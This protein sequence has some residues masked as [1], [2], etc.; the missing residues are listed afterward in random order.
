MRRLWVWFLVLGL[1]SI[2]L[3]AQITNVN[4]GTSYRVDPR[5]FEFFRETEDEVIKSHGTA[6]NA[7][8]I[9]RLENIKNSTRAYPDVGVTQTLYAVNFTTNQFYSLSATTRGVGTHCYVM[10]EDTKWNDSTVTQTIVNNVIAAFDS[11]AN[12]ILTKAP[13]YTPGTAPN[14]DGIY[15]L[16]TYYFGN[17]PDVDSEHRICILLLDIQDGYSGSGGYVGGYFHSYNQGTGTYSNRREIIYIDVYPANPVAID[18]LGTVAHEFQHMIHYNVDSDESTWV[19]EACSEF[20]DFVTTG[21]IRQN[22]SYGPNSNDS[23][24]VWSQEL[25]DYDQVAL[26]ANYFTDQTGATFNINQ[27]AQNAANSTVGVNAAL[28]ALGSSLTFDTM[29]ENW[30]VANYINDRTIDTKYGYQWIDF[31]PMSEYAYHSQFP[32]ATQP[33][34]SVNYTGTR[35]IAF[36]FGK[37]LTVNFNGN[38][39]S[40]VVYA[41]KIGDSGNAVEKMTLDGSNDGVWNFSDFGTTYDKIVLAVGNLTTSGAVSFTYSATAEAGTKELI[42]YDDNASNGFV[43]AGSNLGFGMKFT[44][45]TYPAKIDKIRLYVAGSSQPVQIRIYGSSGSNP[46]SQI[47]T[48]L[49]LTTPSVDG[50]WEIPIT[51]KPQIDSGDFYVVMIQASGNATSIGWDDSTGNIDRS[52]FYNGTS[53]VPSSTGLS[54]PWNARKWLIRAIVDSDTGFQDFSITSHT[55]TDYYAYKSTDAISFSW[56]SAGDDANY[57]IYITKEGGVE[58]EAGSTTSTNLGKNGD[59]WFTGGYGKY[60]VKVTAKGS[61]KDDK[62]STNTIANIYYTSLT[63]PVSSF[64]VLD[65][66]WDNSEF[67]LYRSGDTDLRLRWTDDGNDNASTTYSYEIVWDTATVTKSGVTVTSGSGN[68]WIETADQTFNLGAFKNTYA[69]VKMT[70]AN[71]STPTDRV[72]FEKRFYFRNFIWELLPGIYNDDY[73]QVVALGQNLQGSEAV[74]SLLRLVVDTPAYDNVLTA[75]G[76]G[77]WVGGSSFNTTSFG[78]AAIFKLYYN[79]GTTG[80]STD[81][82]QI[83]GDKTKATYRLNNSPLAVNSRLSFASQTEQTIYTLN[84]RYPELAGV[85]PIQGDIFYVGKVTSSIN[86]ATANGYK[87]MKWESGAWRDCR[88]VT[89]SGY[90][91]LTAGTIPGLKYKTQLTG[92]HP[93]PFNPETTITFAVETAQTVTME[94]YTAKGKIVKSVVINAVEGNNSYHWNGKDDRG[95]DMASGV[96]YCVLKADGKQFVRKMVMLK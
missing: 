68:E 34:I 15:G 5:S 66:Y 74:G 85:S 26:F 39:G 88:S 67:I 19:N 93:N 75:S 59:Q 12:S 63:S 54:A 92:N 24:V 48:P 21:S 61:D 16:D 81:D 58:Y 78:D 30:M 83:G 47:I 51:S 86:Y 11:D 28:T 45:S 79:N 89:A 73:L 41:I 2:N 20:A 42:K 84:V 71:S 6:Q 44:P 9:T 72:Y 77:L 94:L 80:V 69:T 57:Y 43:Y 25:I 4:K 27:L 64:T 96:Y 46:G 38:S 50:W 37:N 56:S 7:M 17:P 14:G 22:A 82:F 60:Q 70:I 3:N 8:E 53:L 1:F 33:S 90:Y 10:V 40:L 52:Y 91:A 55:A 35:Y 29:F 31:A 18:T 95:N 65:N 13:D 36:E 23:L 49:N 76:N 62:D 32:V 87:L